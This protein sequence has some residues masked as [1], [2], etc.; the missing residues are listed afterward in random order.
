LVRVLSGVCGGGRVCWF[1]W[2]GLWVG[3]GGGVAAVCAFVL[4][5]EHFFIIMNAII[6]Q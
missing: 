2:G 6:Y 3:G 5:N 4:K 1:G